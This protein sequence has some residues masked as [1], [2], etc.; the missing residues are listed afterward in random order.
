MPRQ[1]RASV[2]DTKW[3]LTNKKIIIVNNEII[4][5]EIH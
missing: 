2:V 5:K 1:L 3:V 4:G